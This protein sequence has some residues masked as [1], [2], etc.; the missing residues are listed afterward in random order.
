MTVLGTEA[1]RLRA[2]KYYHMQSG[3]FDTSKKLM[4]INMVGAVGHQI[5]IQFEFDRD[6]I[7]SQ[8]QYSYNGGSEL[9]D[10]D[11]EVQNI[12]NKEPVKHEEIKI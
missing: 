2:A 6:Q 5:N 8:S 1:K 11:N 12:A 10:L 4:E 9:D 3:Y 7:S